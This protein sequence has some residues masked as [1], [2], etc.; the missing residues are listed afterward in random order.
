MSD[1]QTYIL[2]LCAQL[3][4][5]GKKPT[6]SLIKQRAN[7]AIP[8]PQIV[9]VL[10]RYKADPAIE[11][12]SVAEQSFEPVPQSLEDKVNELT[13]R[14]IQLETQLAEVLEQLRKTQD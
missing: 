11:V 9:S 8:L 4:Q 6:V 5:Q 2:A 3:S 13:Q 1:T 12:E 10:Q 7:R 14:V